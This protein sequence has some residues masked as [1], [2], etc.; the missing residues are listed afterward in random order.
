MNTE[1][2]LAP[3]TVAAPRNVDLDLFGVEQ[4]STRPTGGLVTQI[5]SKKDETKVLGRK[6]TFDFRTLAEFKA[7]L[8]EDKT[9]NAA[10][11]KAKRQEFLNA[12]SIKQRQMMGMAALQASY[13]PD[14]FAPLG[15]VP[16]SME[17]RKNGSLKLISVEAFIGKDKSE[18]PTQKIARL[19]RELREA[20]ASKA[21]ANTVEAETVPAVE[22]ETVPVES[23]A[24]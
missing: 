18:T 8:A 7:T 20:V 10:A 1:T 4:L 13:A 11:R 9:L 23:A 14:S 22:A 21:E 12:D 24:E 17:L 16:D 2:T 5:V 15:R 3:V 6:V 19:E